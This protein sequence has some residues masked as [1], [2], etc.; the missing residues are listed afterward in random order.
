MCTHTLPP[1]LTTQVTTRIVF[2][3]FHSL[4]IKIMGQSKKSSKNICKKKYF[5]YPFLIEKY[6]V[7]DKQI[8]DDCLLMI[9]NL[10]LYFFVY[11][12]YYLI[13]NC[14]RL[15]LKARDFFFKFMFNVYFIKFFFI[16]NYYLFILVERERCPIYM[17]VECKTITMIG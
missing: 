11:Y 10:I 17:Y 9:H 15:P 8:I 1:N 16:F 12:H 7:S 13:L 4:K 6:S 3:Y 2:L 14:T 5:R